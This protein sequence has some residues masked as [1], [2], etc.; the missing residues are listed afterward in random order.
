MLKI[1]LNIT[2]EIAA[3]KIAL[4]KF[5]INLKQPKL[6]FLKYVNPNLKVVPNVTVPPNLIVYRIAKQANNNGKKKRGNVMM[7]I[8]GTTASRAIKPIRTITQKIDIV[9]KTFGLFE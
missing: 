3:T 4:S 7:L 2:N 8:S 6:G 9:Q 5:L 1:T